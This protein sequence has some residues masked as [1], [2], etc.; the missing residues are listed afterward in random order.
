MNKKWLIQALSKYHM[1]DTPRS[2]GTLH[3][4]RFFIDYLEKLDTSHYDKHDFVHIEHYLP[5]IVADV[6]ER[7][8]TSNDPE[9][10][11][12][13]QAFQKELGRE[14]PNITDLD[15][16]NSLD[17]NSEAME[18]A[19]VLA[20][21]TGQQWVE[22]EIEVYLLAQ[23]TVLQQ[24]FDKFL[25]RVYRKGMF[26][27]I[28]KCE[29]RGMTGKFGETDVRTYVIAG[30]IMFTFAR[31]IDKSKGGLFQ[32]GEQVYSNED[33]V[34]FVGGDDDPLCLSAGIQSI[35][36]DLK[37]GMDMIED[38]IKGW[39]EQEKEQKRVFKAD[40]DVKMDVVAVMEAATE[41]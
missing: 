26:N 3:F 10:L 38:V 24:T 35:H 9:T 7:F 36:A 31:K 1:K 6:C 17:Q 32:E 25:R 22:K 21:V 41:K 23:Q 27:L 19:H 15:Q 8:R 4:I 28:D 20:E 2:K 11:S 37:T 16:S 13:R 40:K 12:S 14:F 33:S 34:S 30:R 39:P 29:E 18:I 5:E